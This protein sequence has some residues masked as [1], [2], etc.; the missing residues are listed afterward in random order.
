MAHDEQDYVDGWQVYSDW[1]DSLRESCDSIVKFDEDQSFRSKFTS[2]KTNKERFEFIWQN[3]E[4]RKD[5]QQVYEKDLANC[6]R[7]QTLRPAKSPEESKRLRDIGNGL[8]KEGKYAEALIVYTEAV[9]YAPHPNLS[10]D[11]P[12]DSLALAVANR[13]ACLYALAR[14]RL[15]LLD[16]ELA[17]KLGYPKANLFKLLIRKVKC[18]HV[19]SVWTND[20]EEIKE[21]LRKMLT[22]KET[23]EFVRSEI[24]AMFEF[25]KQANP[26]DVVKDDGD[27]DEEIEMKIQNPSKVLTNAAD[28][29]EMSHEPEKGRFMIANKDV[30][31]GRL[32][33]IEEPFVCNI[34]PQNRNSYCY[35][36]C[37][38]LYQCGL[39]CPNCSQILYCSTKCQKSNASFHKFECNKFLDFHDR[40][41]VVYLVAHIMFKIKFNL[42]SFKIKTKKS[43][44]NKT[45]DQLLN[46]PAS[47]WPE[48]IYN[49]DY[50]AVLALMDHASDYD[51]DAL[52][53][54]TLTACYLMM[55]FKEHYSDIC[56]K[57]TDENALVIGSVVLRHLMQLQANLISVLD[58]DLRSMIIVGH[59][60]S[61]VKE[62]PI[63]V[64]IYPTMSLLNHSCSPN[65]I[66]IFHRNKLVARSSKTLHC[67]T[68]LNFCYGP[69]MFRMSKK[70]RI[71]RLKEQYFFT[72]TCE[73]CSSSQENE[74]RALLCPKCKGPVIYNQ[75][76]TNKCMKCNEEEVLSTSDALSDIRAM[77]L[78][79]QQVSPDSDQDNLKNILE[80]KKIE[81]ELKKLVFWKHYLFVK[82]K[83]LLIECAEA[84]DDMDLAL[85]YCDE[86]LMLCDKTYGSN[87]FESIMIK[88]KYINF[89]FKS[90]FYKIENSTDENLKHEATEGL[91]KLH[92]TVT[93]TRANLK[94][95]LSSTSI[96][97]AEASFEQ[98]LKFLARIHI[99]INEYLASL[100]KPQ[101]EPKSGSSS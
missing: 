7:R 9:K 69:S 47:D 76:L 68:E 22:N 63:G 30:S 94:E 93:N 34:A 14:Y 61:D 77:Q 65:I 3:E 88:L 79:I 54:Y 1:I 86:E 67:G 74:S 64:A 36:C 46:M 59:S 57:L 49:N 33:I 27:I 73:C 32:L 92:V 90:L 16:I 5:V 85:Q 56:P 70:D 51:Y 13:S 52:M 83:T 8:Y 100:D 87:S 18:L 101:T 84:L 28:C 66:S 80:L 25:L 26:Q 38:R 35:N 12:D 55:A 42:S 75:D 4:I 96:L 71:A 23:K 10:D 97:G 17:I 95:L 29:V 43:T 91:K 50:P 99:N 98:E 45:L 37:R 20:V 58:Q 82:V 48:V 21:T 62:R 44:E 2:L 41:G 53:G 31:F 72:C 40:I 78:K 60:L 39:S 89:K 11:Q 81:T 15:C 19:I 6:K 24:T